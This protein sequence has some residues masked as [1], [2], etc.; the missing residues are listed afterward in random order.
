MAKRI[1]QF[2]EEEKEDEA[3]E[4]VSKNKDVM[5]WRDDASRNETLIHRAARGNCHT[6]LKKVFGNEKMVIIS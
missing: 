2:L 6:F 1:K 4:E 5:K 3:I